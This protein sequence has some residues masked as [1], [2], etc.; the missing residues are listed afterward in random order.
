ME[1]LGAVAG[2]QQEGL[3]LPATSAEVLG[4]AP[5]LAG[6]DEWRACVASSASTRAEV[7][8][9]R[10]TS[11]SGRRARAPRARAPSRVRSIPSS[12]RT[13][14]AGR[15]G[16]SPPNLASVTPRRVRSLRGDLQPAAP[17][18]RRRTA[19]RGRDG[20]LRPARGD[21]RRRPLPEERRGRPDSPAAAAPRDGRGGV[22][23]TCPWSRCRTARSCARARP[24]RST[25]C[26]SC[27]RTATWW[28]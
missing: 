3:A 2:L 4:E 21:R 5:G 20:P 14:S 26:G 16:Q 7:L 10:A 6:E 1:G 19:R 23:R 13:G 15:G 25:R 11:G 8:A 9:R 18:P 27:W 28:T 22:R 17:R 12:K 24:T